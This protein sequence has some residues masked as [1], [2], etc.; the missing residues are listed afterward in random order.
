MGLKKHIS[1][2]YP[3]TILLH[4]VP[5]LKRF[6]IAQSSVQHPCCAIKNNLSSRLSQWTYF[7][8]KILQFCCHGHIDK[9]Q[10]FPPRNKWQLCSGKDKK[11]GLML[12]NRMKFILLIINGFTS[13][14]YLHLSITFQK[15]NVYFLHCQAS[16]HLYYSVI[17]YL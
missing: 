10:M 13:S 9:H 3:I 5:C 11:T 14:F 16:L 1:F 6:S 2:F 8:T 4:S 7:V 15:K 17:L 12:G